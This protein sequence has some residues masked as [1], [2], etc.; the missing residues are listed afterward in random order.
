MLVRQRPFI[1]NFMDEDLVLIDFFFIGSYGIDINVIHLQ[2][3]C[4]LFIHE[5][6]MFI[7]IVQTRMLYVYL[8][9]LQIL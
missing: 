5:C 1:T 2:T 6:Y 8:S 7:H 9:H 4:A 3:S